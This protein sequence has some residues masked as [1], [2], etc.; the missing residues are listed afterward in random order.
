MDF[1]PSQ[2]EDKRK[3]SFQKFCQDTIAATAAEVDSSGRIPDGHWQAL[4]D[5]GYLEFGLDGGGHSLLQW[6]MLG[7]DLAASCASTFAAVLA[8]SHLFAT[9]VG[10][11]GSDTQ[12]QKYLPGISKGTIKAAVALTDPKG[13]PDSG[14]H[15]TYAE[16]TAD[17]ALLNGSKPYVS[18]G[19]ICDL[20]LVLAVTGPESEPE[21]STVFIVESGA[22]GL[23]KGA[24]IETMGIRGCEV[25]KLSF[26]GCVVPEDGVLGDWNNGGK[27]LGDLRTLQRIWWAAYGVGVGQAC[28]DAA[29]EH[30]SKR[31]LGE[32]RISKYEE[33]HF[34]VAEMHMRTDTARQL[35]RKAAWLMD[36]GQNASIIAAAAKLL[37]TESATDS[38]HKA[39][40]IHGGRGFVRG[41]TVERLYRDARLGEI[42]GETSEVLRILLARD[43]LQKYPV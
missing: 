20:A 5:F 6:T 15:R 8:S 1:K 25:G 17:G 42:E 37:A 19:P 31:R 10:R 34:K 16:K 28:I 38:S 7:E 13:A 32:K 22:D 36:E 2:E 18:N 24:R 21:G 9:I 4:A 43:V 29:I 12:K 23:D 3:R 39:V 35:A 30:A 26:D 41:S 27:I 33:I 14:P 11:H 40:Q